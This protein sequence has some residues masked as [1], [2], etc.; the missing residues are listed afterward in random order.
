MLKK[1][2]IAAAL[3]SALGGCGLKGNLETPPPIFGEP[4]QSEP[5][6]E[7]AED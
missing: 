6:P 5:A 4:E 2:L 7:T 1:T 3:L